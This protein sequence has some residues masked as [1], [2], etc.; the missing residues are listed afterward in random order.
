M[1]GSQITR[2]GR[3]ESD[4]RELGDDNQDNQSLVYFVNKSEE[5]TD[6]PPIY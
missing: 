2:Y 5:P 3:G 1:M 6:E 4:V